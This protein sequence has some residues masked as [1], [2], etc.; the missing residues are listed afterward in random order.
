MIRPSCEELVVGVAL[1]AQLSLAAVFRPWRRFPM[2]NAA[3]SAVL[4]DISPPL[5]REVTW[6]RRSSEGFG[7]GLWC[8]APRGVGSR[9]QSL[10]RGPLPLRQAP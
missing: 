1:M 3:I 5:S 10:L 8:A 7:W 4:M 9:A 6:P 2:M